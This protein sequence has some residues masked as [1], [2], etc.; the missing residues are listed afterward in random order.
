MNIF[1]DEAGIFVIPRKK[2]SSVSCVG[3]LMMPERVTRI[4][5]DEFL[6]LKESW[7]VKEG[8]IK[9]SKLNEP[10][11][12]SLIR[13]L[14]RHD[15]IFQV[16]AVDMNMQ[17]AKEL[18][19]HKE[20]QAKALTKNLTEKHH[21]NLV[22]AL[23]DLQGQLLKLPTQ[24]YVQSCCTFELL[25]SSL[26]KATLYYSQ[27][28]PEEIGDF[29]WYIDAKDKEITPFEEFWTK[30]VLASLQSKSF[31][32]PFIQLIEADYSHFIKYCDEKDEPPEHIKDAVS[33]LTPFQYVNINDIYKKHLK[34][35]QSHTNP[36]IQMVDILTTSIRRAMNGALNPSG[37]ELI[38]QL[39]VQSQKGSH[40]IELISLCEEQD[41]YKTG[42]RPPYWSVI[43]IVDR[44]CKPMLI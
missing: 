33:Q 12:A 22:K 11:V 3:A 40:A 7:G 43:P 28:Q 15:I 31:R 39:M 32:E 37:W 1:V 44:I 9:G 14:S 42:K 23:R 35:D 29:Y 10:E 27:R 5:F 38:G 24:L 25:S 4:V 20:M 17:S 26:Q 2:K 16:T 13:L 18:E 34:F 19:Y 36:G 41:T 8:E 21:E 30:V 6:K